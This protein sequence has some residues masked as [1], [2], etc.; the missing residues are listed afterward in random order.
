MAITG[1]VVRSVATSPVVQLVSE[2]GGA[3]GTPRPPLEAG[4]E[5]RAPLEVEAGAATAGSGACG[6]GTVWIFRVLKASFIAPLLSYLASGAAST[7]DALAAST[8][9]R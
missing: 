9:C 1:S 6:N 5:T 3:R 2:D 4:G 8:R 7:T